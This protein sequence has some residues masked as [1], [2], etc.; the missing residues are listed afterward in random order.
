VSFH[1]KQQDELLNA[2]EF[3]IVAV[4]KSMGAA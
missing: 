1:G 3:E 4:A 2:E